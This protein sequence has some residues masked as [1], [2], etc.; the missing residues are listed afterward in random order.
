M[1]I[2]RRS[3]PVKKGCVEQALALLRDAGQS[4][5]HPQGRPRRL[6]AANIGAI[7]MVA[8]EIEF[9]TL[10]EY[11]A[12]WNAVAAEPWIGNFFAQWNTITEAG[13]MNEIWSAE[14]V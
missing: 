11:E 4:F 12:Y 3:Y 10:A 2:N 7:D 1:L 13:G 8:F 9:A 6:Y 14:P 5:A